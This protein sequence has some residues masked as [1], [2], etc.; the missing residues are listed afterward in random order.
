MKSMYNTIE[1]SRKAN[2]KKIQE[3]KIMLRERT[4]KVRHPIFKTIWLNEK[5]TKVLE[6]E[7]FRQLE[8]KS[9]LGTKSLSKGILNAKHSRL[10]HSIGTMHLTRLV[11]DIC[12]KKFSTYLTIT[13]KEK[14]ALEL[15]AL[16]HDIGHIAFSHSLEKLIDKTH[17]QRTIEIFKKNAEE[18]NKIFG[19]DITT[20]VIHI[21]QKNIE[22]KKE[23][24]KIQG[25]EELDILSI[26][27][28]LLIGTI[29]CDRIE[30]LMTDRH[31]IYGEKIDFI[32]IF[33]Y[34]VI[35]LIDNKPVVAFEKEAVPM[36]E[37]LLFTRLDNYINDYHEKDGNI[38][39][40]AIIDYIKEVGWEKQRIE[41][42]ME[43]EILAELQKELV[44]PNKANTIQH[45]LAEIVLRGKR[46]N[47]LYKK[48]ENIKEYQYFL[49]RLYTLTQKRNKI[50]TKQTRI[51]VYDPNKNRVYIKDENG[52][53]KDILEVSNKIQKL[54]VYIGYIIIDVEAVYGFSE[55]EIKNIKS[56]FED[57]LVEIEK[58][59]I[60]PENLTQ[61]DIEKI[62][63]N[64]PQVE[65]IKKWE[66]YEN[67]DLYYNPI[68]PIPKG[69]AIRSREAQNIKT[70]YIKMPADD[71]T[72]ITKR[73]EYAYKECNSLEEFLKLA[74]NLFNTKKIQLEGKL[75]VVEGVQIVTKRKKTL[76]K[77]Q[78]SIIEIA[79]D[80]STYK[81]KGKI[82][83]GHM[84]ECELKQGNDL[85][86]WYISKYLK[87][88][89]F[90]EISKS[91]KERAEKALGIN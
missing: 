63:E 26:F 7:E 85:S 56:L 58:K 88:Q 54:S 23:G 43:F 37:N 60:Y 9:Q 69:I 14:E 76:I 34:I 61:E 78:D 48:F 5:F 57:N 36:L 72:S 66:T 52:V 20:T 46:K 11:L 50:V 45:R 24:I 74:T 47:I 49:E 33:Q 79:C 40:E 6:I 71:G 59:F 2:F 12:E 81:Y 15:A 44:D 32:A 87:E 28:N 70:Y 53:V 51:T 84:L 80:F 19:Y 21:Y 77:I 73:E 25:K 41:K 65:Q 4:T 39:E 30:Y 75:E 90:K 82:A 18:I 22:V 91:K 13:Q 29:D 10:M 42:I 35:E 83:E 27:N 89:G 55:K 16:G 1:K 38:V 67:R 17:E 8:F 62:L 64:M 86:L 3:E 68:I 31:M